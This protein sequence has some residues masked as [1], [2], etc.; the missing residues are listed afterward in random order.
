[1]NLDAT[2]VDEE[3]VRRIFGPGKRAENILPD[4]TLSPA[5]EAIV[6]RFPGAINISAIGPAATAFER[7]DD[8]A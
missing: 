5:H 1:M 3:P 4:A 8:P 7:M 2:A 6:E